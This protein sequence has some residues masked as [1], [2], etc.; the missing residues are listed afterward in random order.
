M[1]PEKRFWRTVALVV[2]ASLAVWTAI[3]I[4]LALRVML[5]GHP[6]LIVLIMIVAVTLLLTPVPFYAYLQ[7]T[8]GLKYSR[9]RNILVGLYYA[10]MGA[11]WVIVFLRWPTGH[12]LHPRFELAFAFTWFLVAAIRLHRAFKPE[13]NVLHPS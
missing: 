12:N 8:I 13:D 10:C 7:G 5:Q 4:F 2:V 1:R 3:S 9:R 6:R 11:A